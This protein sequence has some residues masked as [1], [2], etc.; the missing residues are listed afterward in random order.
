MEDEHIEQII[1]AKYCISL[2]NS[3]L[4]HAR[5]YKANTLCAPIARAKSLRVLKNS[6]RRNAVAEGHF[7]Y[8]D[9]MSHTN[10][11]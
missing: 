9:I 5:I 11:F 10:S 8:P 3:H 7:R 2:K 1:I 4:A 6:D